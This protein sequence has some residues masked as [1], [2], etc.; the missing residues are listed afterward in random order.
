MNCCIDYLRKHIMVLYV[1]RFSYTVIIMLFAFNA[2]GND[3]LI[4][5]NIS[6]DLTS[7]L[8]IPHFSLNEHQQINLPSSEKLMTPL[9]QDQ[10]GYIFF[11]LDYYTA[12]I[13]FNEFLEATDVAKILAACYGAKD[14]IGTHAKFIYDQ[15]LYYNKNI[16]RTKLKII[17]KQINGSNLSDIITTF[18]RIENLDASGCVNITTWC[19]NLFT[20]VKYLKYLNIYGCQKIN[21]KN[22]LTIISLRPNLIH[23]NI[24]QCFHFTNTSATNI[25]NYCPNLTYL[26]V[27]YCKRITNKG[28]AAFSALRRLTYLNVSDTNITDKGCLFVT[29]L[30]ELQHFEMQNCF[31]TDRT[32][33]LISRQRSLTSLNLRFCSNATTNGLNLLTTLINLKY[34][35]IFCC[36]HSYYNIKYDTIKLAE[37]LKKHLP[38]LTVDL[39]P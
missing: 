8:R 39:Q 6:R 4:Q 14:K 16:T 10:R 22:I 38:N 32:L 20:Q 35:S 5:T 1:V 25:K 28:F 30:Q 23:L 36:G 37:K 9:I 3:E 34:L 19:F 31:I 7:S 24:G 17:N 15:C 26:D 12:N 18:P 2:K 13:F 11:N 33:R 21:D 27:S 29:D